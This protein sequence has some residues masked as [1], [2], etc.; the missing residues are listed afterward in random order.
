MRLHILYCRWGFHLNSLYTTHPWKHTL[1]EVRNWVIRLFCDLNA[2]CTSR[3]GDSIMVACTMQREGVTRRDQVNADDVAVEGIEPPTPL[4]TIWLYQMQYDRIILALMLPS[5][6]GMQKVYIVCPYSSSSPYVVTALQMYLMG[7]RGWAARLC[8][9]SPWSVSVRFFSN[10]LVLIVHDVPSPLHTWHTSA[11]ASE[12]KTPS[13][14]MFY[15][16]DMYIYVGTYVCTWN[17]QW[18][19][20]IM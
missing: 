8:V 2:G 6:L 16:W 18:Q 14:P 9:N 1:T 15:I 11:L 13:Q 12:S 4:S 10:V 7:N 19:Q 20:C 5:L 3:D 17:N